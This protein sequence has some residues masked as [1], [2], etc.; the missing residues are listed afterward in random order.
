MTVE[1]EG[2]CPDQDGI[3]EVRK[4]N[5][6]VDDSVE[7]LAHLDVAKCIRGGISF[8]RTCLWESEMLWTGPRREYSGVIP[9]MGG[10]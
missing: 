8:C 3:L 5:R 10:G 7:V 2:L 1:R 9:V 4:G 6:P